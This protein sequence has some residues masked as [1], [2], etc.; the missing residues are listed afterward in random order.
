[1]FFWI[2]CG[3][4]TVLINLIFGNQIGIETLISN[5][6][7]V[8]KQTVSSFQKYLEIYLRKF[9]CKLKSLFLFPRI[10]FNKIY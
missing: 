9:L 7:G 5:H 1:M 4:V 10:T 8:K 6:S 3:L 2:L